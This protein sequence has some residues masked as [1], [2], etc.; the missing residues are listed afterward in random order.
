[1]FVSYRSKPDIDF[2]KAND[3]IRHNVILANYA[4]SMAIDNDDGSYNFDTHNNVFIYGVCALKSDYEGHSNHHHG[5]FYAFVSGGA[6]A[7]QHPPPQGHQ[8]VFANNQIVFTEDGGQ[9]AGCWGFELK[10][11]VPWNQTHIWTWNNTGYSPNANVTECNVPL[12]EWV[13]AGYDHG[14]T[15]K[16]T[17][18]TTALLEIASAVLNYD[19]GE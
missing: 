8:D 9:V 3:T 5:N 12:E 10:T 17:P 18:D 2:Y 14:S 6:C 4:S 11:K 1:L 16:K 7:G 15:A 19:L 13:K